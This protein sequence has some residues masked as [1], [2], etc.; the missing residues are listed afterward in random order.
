MLT[1]EQEWYFNNKA[2]I[3]EQMAAVIT[4]GRAGQVTAG[5]KTWNDALSMLVESCAERVAVLDRKCGSEVPRLTV[6]EPM[7]E[8]EA[9]K[10]SNRRVPKVI[11]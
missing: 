9:R 10:E 1:N 7:S 8:D 11:V 2:L 6:T 5:A 3:A 4:S